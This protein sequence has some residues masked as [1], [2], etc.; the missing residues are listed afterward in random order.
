M[1][2]GNNKEQE[3]EQAPVADCHFGILKFDMISFH[4]KMSLYGQLI[5]LQTINVKMS[6][7]H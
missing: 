2:G 6:H 7:L 5:S 4:V 1:K 3:Q